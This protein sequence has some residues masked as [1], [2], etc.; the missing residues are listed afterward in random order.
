MDGPVVVI[1]GGIVG[2][3]IA[4]ELQMSQTTTILVERDIEPQGA[5]AFSFAS[6]SAFDAAQ[7]DVYLLKTHGMIGWRQWSK[8]FGAELG[9]SF[10]GELRW[11]E[12]DEGEGH[13][14]SLFERAASR[15]Y[16]VRSISREEIIEREPAGRPSSVRLACFAEDD[17]Q[18]DPVRAIDVLRGAFAESGGTVL[19]GRASVMVEDSG[20]TVRIGDDRV[21]ASTVV[22]ATGAETT[23]LLERLGW[24]IPMAPSPGLLSVTDPVERFLTGTVYVY[25]ESGTPVHLRQAADGRVVIGERSQDEVARNP[26]RNH[27]ER[28]LRQARRSFPALDATGVDHFTVE[29]R[30]M[31]RDGLPIVG[32]LPGLSSLYVATGHSGVTV[33]PAVARFVTQE[34]VHGAPVP[35]LKAFRPARFSVQQVDV[36]RDIEEVFNG[37][38]EMFIG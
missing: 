6:L 13:L 3:A 7:R 20:T 34:I 8:V 17:G 36:A 15:G 23:N 31:P 35:R 10:P 14:K 16:P 27:A 25:P 19:V 29:W 2:T 33:A 1:G 32:P 4:Y 21:E 28:L 11:A 12:S 5:S 22:I 30:P 9:V 26:S 18:A 24:A 38:P 37:E